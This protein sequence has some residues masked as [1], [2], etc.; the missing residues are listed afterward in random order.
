MTT[1]TT[2]PDRTRPAPAGLSEPDRQ[3]Q[4]HPHIQQEGLNWAVFDTRWQP[5]VDH[6]GE[7]PVWPRKTVEQS[8]EAIVSMAVLDA[9]GP[10]GQY[11]EDA[12]PVPW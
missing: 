1:V 3:P 2:W 10:T 6:A 11:V 9:G 7:L 4:T 5:G 8:A 12:G